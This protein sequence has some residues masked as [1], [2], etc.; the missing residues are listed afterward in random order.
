MKKIIGYWITFL[1][2]ILIIISAAKQRSEAPY[3]NI[4]VYTDSVVVYLRGNE[5]VIVPDHKIWITKRY[6]IEITDLNK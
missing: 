5:R 6:K 3:L 4:Q 2:P 1:I